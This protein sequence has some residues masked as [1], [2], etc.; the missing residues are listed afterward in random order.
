MADS[1]TFSFTARLNLRNLY[2]FVYLKPEKGPLLPNFS[3]LQRF[4]LIRF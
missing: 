2:A 4:Y 3:M 1:A